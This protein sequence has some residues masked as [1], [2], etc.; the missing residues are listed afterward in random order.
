MPRPSPS[1]AEF[2]LRQAVPGPEHVEEVD[3]PEP[4]PHGF[5]LVGFKDVQRYLRRGKTEL[6]LQARDVLYDGVDS[7]LN[8]TPHGFAR[9]GFNNVQHLCRDGKPERALQACDVLCDGVKRACEQAIEE[10]DFE[11]AA[12]L[13]DAER[14]LTSFRKTFREER[15]RAERR[16]LRPV[17]FR[18]PIGGITMRGRSRAARCGTPRAS[19]SRR[20]A[21]RPGSGS[22][23]DPG[24]GESE[25][26]R[27]RP[28]R[29]LHH[30]APISIGGRL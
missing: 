5:A 14:F 28:G 30:A 8:S 16:D 2:D 12:N 6:A 25:S 15:H 27:L 23:G 1:D 21:A 26:P 19:G 7:A 22:R 13:R 10:G 24:E 4:P 18:R 9:V 11:E 20:S 17:H 3:A 29:H